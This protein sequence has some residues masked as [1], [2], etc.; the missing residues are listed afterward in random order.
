V[1]CDGQKVYYSG[2]GVPDWRGAM[3]PPAP[4]LWLKPIA[5]GL[6]IR[7]N[8][9]RS[10]TATDIFTGQAD[11]EGYRVYYGLDTRKASFTLVAAYDRE[12]FDKYVWL[13]VD[14]PSEFSIYDP[15]FTTDSLRVLYGSGNPDFDP[16]DFTEEN[17]YRH[18]EYPESLFYFM[19]HSY[20]VSALGESTPIRRV[21]PDEPFPVS[22]DPLANPEEARTPEGN[23]KYYEYEYTLE[24]LLPTVP[25]YVNVTAMDFGAPEYRLTGLE[26]SVT[27]GA[28]SAYPLGA[29][30]SEDEPGGKIFV[31]PNPYRG[32]ADYRSQGLEGRF[33]IDRPD[34]RVRAINFANLPPRCTIYI[35][36]LDGDLV[37]Q[38]DHD[39]DP[40]DP[41]SS[42]DNWDLITRNTQMVVSGL[43][44]WVIESEDG[45]TQ[46][47]KIVIIF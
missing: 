21:Y 25:Y 22:P 14:R 13:G 43:Y 5:N 12:D 2:D 9:T 26:T 11:F 38:L 19:P 10:E 16:L 20:N 31:Y 33:E 39:F 23:L 8:G 41:M 36:S 30:A 47:G 7:F 28:K 18:P 42:H 1:D 45:S 37:R 34:H 29:S 44:Y 15:P 46:M 32:D 3:P 4:D 17:M 35:Y 40:S 27:V 6:K 24:N